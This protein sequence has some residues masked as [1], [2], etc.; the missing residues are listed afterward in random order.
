MRRALECGPVRQQGSPSRHAKQQ[1][2]T[3]HGASSGHNTHV[4]SSLP[5]I[6]RLR[7]HVPPIVISKTMRTTNDLSAASSDHPSP[8]SAMTKSTMLTVATTMNVRIR[9]RGRRFTAADPA[10]ITVSATVGLAAGADNVLFEDCKGS[11]SLPFIRCRIK[12]A[13]SSGV[14]L[15]MSI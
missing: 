13:T 15:S 7:I 12:Y 5:P 11:V 6:S 2:G 10:L 8:A 1:G 3:G 14:L 9:N 4:L